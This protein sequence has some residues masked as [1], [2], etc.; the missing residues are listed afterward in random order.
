MKR[1]TRPRLIALVAAATAVAT[2]IPLALVAAE[3]PGPNGPVA[4]G[5]ASVLFLTRSTKDFLQW[6]TFKETIST[7]KNDCTAITFTG[8]DLADITATGVGGVLGD[9]KDGFGELSPTDGTGEPCGRIDAPDQGVSVALSGKLSNYAMTAV[10]ADLEL[11]FGAIALLEFRYNGAPVDFNYLA[12]GSNTTIATR[13]GRVMFDSNLPNGDDGP[14]SKDGDNYRVIA[15]PEQCEDLSD[16][17]TC[18][19][20]FFDEIV[21]TAGQGAVSLE[22]GADL[23]SNPSSSAYGSLYNAANDRNSL[24]T[25]FEVVRVYDG[26]LDCGDKVVVGDGVTT[27]KGEFTR[28]DYGK[29]GD[30]C[31]LKYYDLDSAFD[32]ETSENTILFSPTSTPTVTARYE[33]E[34]TSVPYSSSGENPVSQAIQYDPEGDGTYSTMLWCLENPT[35]WNTAPAGDVLPGT[36]SWCITD[37]ATTVGSDGKIQTTWSVIGE[38]DPGF[39]FG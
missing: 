16:D 25:Q 30:V 8:D 38:G 12:P 14:D 37:V 19:A 4:S 33:A 32:S 39:K 1:V 35:N 22:G 24:S 26:T 28:N 13:I 34:L 6:S 18:T 36:E 17:T 7:R 20:A 2:L 15:R 29:T 21:F 31:V 10:D 3:P 11:K 9:V 27:P 5:N 23:E